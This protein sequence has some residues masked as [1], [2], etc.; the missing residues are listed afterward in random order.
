[1]RDDTPCLV[2]GRDGWLALNLAE[3]IIGDIDRRSGS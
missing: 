3:A 2:S 1:V